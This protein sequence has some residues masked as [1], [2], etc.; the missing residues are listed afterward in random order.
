MT[1]S[2]VV[3]CWDGSTTCKLVSHITYIVLVKTLNTAQSIIHS[4][5]Q[6]S[7]GVFRH[8]AVTHAIIQ[9]PDNQIWKSTVTISTKLNSV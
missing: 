4:T 1:K 6:S 7:P 2:T 3:F 9:N 5:T 8:N